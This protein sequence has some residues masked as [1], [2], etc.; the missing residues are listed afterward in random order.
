MPIDCT[1][2]LTRQ[3][4]SRQIAAMFCA[5]LALVVLAVDLPVVH[6]QH[7]TPGLFDEDCPLVRLAAGAPRV[8]QPHAVDAPRPLTAPDA[9]LLTAAVRPAT[10]RAP[11]SAPRAPPAVV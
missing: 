1:N 11:S 2:L 9:P 8:P 7:N 6:H 10:L 4:T 3:G 5:V